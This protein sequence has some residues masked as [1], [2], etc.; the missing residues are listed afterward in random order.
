MDLPPLLRFRPVPVRAQRN[1]WT[2]DLQRG[3]I[4]ALARG[5]GPDE[6]A[7]ALGRTR[8]SA[9]RLRARPD[10][11]SFAAAWDRAQE[12]ARQVS[13]A[14]RG[15]RLGLQSVDTLLVP[16]FYRGRLVGF[17]QRDDVGALMRALARIDRAAA[18]IG[19]ADASR[20]CRS[21]IHKAPG[22]DRSDEIAS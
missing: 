10:A 19:A 2:P 17:T 8:Q 9:Y 4:L 21:P 18:Q 20:A 15:P 16:R 11:A 1:G 13:V 7:R 14:G 5:A 3:F 12:F 22:S 6:A